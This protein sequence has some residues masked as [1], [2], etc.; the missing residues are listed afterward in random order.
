[1]LRPQST[2]WLT[3]A[4]S[5]IPSFPSRVQEYLPI[6]AGGIQDRLSMEKTNQLFKYLNIIN[7]FVSPYPAV[8]ST[9]QVVNLTTFQYEVMNSSFAIWGI[10]GLYHC[11]K[12]KLSD[13]FP[14]IVIKGAIFLAPPT[15]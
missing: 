15:F 12:E 6:A 4:F 7:A 2:K 14:S 8:N 9:N 5:V 10:L 13:L 1:M 11:I 3:L